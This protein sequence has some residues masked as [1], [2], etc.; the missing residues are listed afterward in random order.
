MATACRDQMIG[1]ILDDDGA[2]VEK[3]GR[4]K[5]ESELMEFRTPYRS[6]KDHLGQ[7]NHHAPA[8]HPENIK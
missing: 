7:G 6:A 1:S 4:P 8:E 5:G 3:R 2:K